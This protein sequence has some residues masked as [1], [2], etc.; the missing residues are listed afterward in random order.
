[1]QNNVIKCLKMEDKLSCTE[2]LTADVA[3]R[4]KI[5]EQAYCMMIK[6]DL[7]SPVAAAGF[8]VTCPVS[9]KL[10]QI[11]ALPLYFL[12]FSAALL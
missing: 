8:M 6:L 9:H 7:E 4:N 1:M 11:V 3:L 5:K 12:V 2:G 10:H